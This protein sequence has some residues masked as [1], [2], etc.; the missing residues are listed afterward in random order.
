MRNFC[1]A[2]LLPPAPT[3]LPPAW[4]L[5]QKEGDAAEGRDKE[6]G[7]GEQRKVRQQESPKQG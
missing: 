1:M 4:A 6:A 7:H 3:G 5:L 2:P